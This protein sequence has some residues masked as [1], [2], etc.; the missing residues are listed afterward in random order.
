MAQFVR[1]VM[2]PDPVV[3][4]ARA[5]I[6]TAA[7]AMRTHDIGD[8]VVTGEDRIQGI[9][10]D[11][12]IVV[13]VLA[14]QKHPAATNAGDVCT[15]S[16]QTVDADARTEDAVQMMRRHTL[17]R[18]PVVNNERLVGIV[19]I[20]DLAETEDPRSALADISRSEPNI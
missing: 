12:D 2:Q 3:V 20:G 14:E 5:S 9:L 17:R 8:V 7:Q 13:R 6:E 19:S 1:D 18:L 10:T 15:Q 11:R 16:V 4:D